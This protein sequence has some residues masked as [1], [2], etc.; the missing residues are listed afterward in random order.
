MTT[1]LEHLEPI[2]IANEVMMNPWKG[3]N[4]LVE[5]DTDVNFYK[6]CFNKK[7][8]FSFYPGHGKVRTRRAVRVLHERQV[9]N[10]IAIIDADFDIINNRQY[11]DYIF[12]TD[13][14]DV[15]TM[16]IQSSAFEKVINEY[17]CRE[18]N[19]LTDNIRIALVENGITVG[20]IRWISEK[21]NLDIPM[22]KIDFRNC[23]N[24]DDEMIDK[25]LL[26]KELKISVNVQ[27][28]IDKCI[29]EIN[30]TALDP[31]IISRG[32]DLVSILLILIKY[33]YGYP[34]S[35][36]EDDLNHL[37]L[38]DIERNLRLAFSTEL[39]KQTK[40]YKMVCLYARD[41]LLNEV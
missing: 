24:V 17:C 41:R 23:F 10:S 11:D 28:R 40:L 34:V 38:E 14:Y 4:V 21:E 26:Y 19:N 12:L 9:N 7:N 22:A 31:W 35:D 18:E 6:D 2:D 1:V 30:E 39:F 36:E 25:K 16:I 33:K 15:E 27:N 3:L 8:E 37:Q 13:T 32:H 5:G 20:L 29:S